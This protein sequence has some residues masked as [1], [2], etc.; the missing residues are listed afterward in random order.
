[1]LGEL[2]VGETQRK[3]GRLVG[4]GGAEGFA[5]L[6]LRGAGASGL[7][8]LA[9]LEP[10]ALVGKGGLLQEL[11]VALAKSEPGL[12]VGKSG[13]LGKLGILAGGAEGEI[14][15]GE[16]G[17]LGI[18]G[19]SKNPLLRVLVIREARLLGELSVL[20]SA[21]GTDGLIGQRC[22]H[23]SACI[24]ILPSHV[25]LVGGL[26][27]AGGL[28]QDTS[29]KGAAL[30]LALSGEAVAVQHL[31]GQRGVA[32]GEPPGGCSRASGLDS[33]AGLLGG[34]AAAKSQVAGG[35]GLELASQSSSSSLA[36]EGLLGGAGLYI[37]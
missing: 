22:L 5:L 3:I 34:K 20:H 17:L 28:V 13:L 31:G 18:T 26:L 23:G 11:C 32:G 7:V 35:L 27:D 10:C 15:I 14:L 25:G 9:C 37:P 12:L 4:E 16:T 2:G 36:H 1:M 30:C 29:S 21:V 8:D 6:E 24:G 33:V 19:L